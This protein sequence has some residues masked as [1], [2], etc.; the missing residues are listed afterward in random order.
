M[1]K[2]AQLQRGEQDQLRTERQRLYSID[3]KLGSSIKRTRLPSR[4]PKADH[5]SS[6]Q[7]DLEELEA[8]QRR[9]EALRKKK[10]QKPKPKKPVAGGG[11]QV[12]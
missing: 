4:K 3:K 8:R 9:R 2:Q 7:R 1:E 5:R 6:Y 12:L 11:D 10:T